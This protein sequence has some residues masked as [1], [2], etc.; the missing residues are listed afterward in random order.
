MVKITDE[1]IRIIS[2]R[3]WNPDRC[4]PLKAL[5]WLIGALCLAPVWLWLAKG[6]VK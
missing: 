1:A 6:V 2:R 4:M 3:R 5:W